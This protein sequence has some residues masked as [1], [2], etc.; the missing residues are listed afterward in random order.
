VTE[1]LH[2][3]ET[4]G[5]VNGFANGAK[6]VYFDPRYSITAS[7][8]HEYYAIRPLTDHAFLLAMIN[9]VINEELYDKQ[10]VAEYTLGFDELKQRVQK[11]TPEW[12]A[13]ITE[14]PAEAIRRIAREM[15]EK[16]P[17]VFVYAPRR[18][19]RSSNDFGTGMTITIL[20]TLL[21][22]GATR[23]EFLPL[24]VTPCRNQIYRNLNTQRLIVL[25]VEEISI[26]S[27]QMSPSNI[28]RTSMVSF[29]VRM[30]P[31]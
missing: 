19:T 18:L 7:K 16:A 14:V 23:G 26:T 13:P 25:T 31:A 12:A 3:G 20:N 1:S 22:F 27:S 10:F 21:V 5:W 9:V 6:V 24:K 28:S 11:Y 2:N 17:S 8:A 29:I 4:L 30:V 15:A